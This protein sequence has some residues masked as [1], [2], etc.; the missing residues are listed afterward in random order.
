MKRHASKEA[1]DTYL[2]KKA[3]RYISYNDWLICD[4]EELNRGKKNKK[5]REKFTSVKDMLKFLD[6]GSR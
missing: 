6:K 4:K 5:I 2:N 3:L 1:I